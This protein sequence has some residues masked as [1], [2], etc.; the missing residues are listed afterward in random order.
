MHEY[1]NPKFSTPD[2]RIDVDKN[3]PVFGWIPH[4]VDA[5][6]NPEFYAEIIAAGGIAAYVA[7]PPYVAP[8]DP[9]LEALDEIAKA[10]PKARRDVVKAKLYQARGK[11][12]IE[13]VTL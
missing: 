5:T 9:I 3:H 6:E 2:G 13:R 7:P 10:L 8:P 12:T 1:K 11:R 4:T